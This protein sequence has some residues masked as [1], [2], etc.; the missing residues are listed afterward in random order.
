MPGGFTLAA[1]EDIAGSPGD[2]DVDTFEGVASLLDKSL[3]RQEPGADGEPR[4]P[5]LEMVREFA[6]EQLA[7]SGEE[8]A[9]RARHA[10]WCLSLAEEAGRNLGLGQAQLPW[11]ARLDAELDN[12]RAALAWF[13]ETGQRSQILRLTVAIASYWEVRPYQAEVL[14][15]LDVGLCASPEAASGFRALAHCLAT[16]MTFDLGDDAATIAHVEHAIVLAEESGDRFILG[17]AHFNAMFAWFEVGDTA[18][19]A[20]SG[21][22]A[23]ALL[24]E[25]GEPFWIAT[26]LA[27]LGDIRLLRGDVAGAVPLLDE[28]LAIL[29]RLGSSWSLTTTLG[30]RGYAALLTGDEVL[31]A[32]LLAES[33]AVAEAMG[34]MR[35]LI[36]AVAGLA[37]VAL[38]LGQPGRAARLLGAVDAAQE[39]SGILR[40]ALNSYAARMATETRARLS[41]AAFTTA[42]DEGRALRFADAMADALALASS[43][44]TRERPGDGAAAAPR[45]TARE[46]DV[47]RLLAQGHSDKEIA[48]ALFI[49][50]R[51]VQSHVGNIFAKLGVNA[52][53]EAAAVA[54]RRGLV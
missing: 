22:K 54:V 15:W 1:A 29:R 44:D 30:E 48:A 45:L 39:S 6:L 37:G 28:A 32:N 21:E 18:R 35:H 49:G 27:E 50:A 17:Q 10:A 11:L 43:V 26:V 25:H 51:T 33:I 40:T 36:G 46:L 34:D 9:I 20:V 31:A 5:I 13:D 52:R 23:L 47:L 24:R 38:A 16:F 41:E 4:F 3:L 42:W 12:L 2:A 14:R 8:A 53:A 7:A 19:A